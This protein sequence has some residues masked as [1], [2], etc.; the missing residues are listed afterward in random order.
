MEL[1]GTNPDTRA[2]L[3]VWAPAFLAALA[4]TGAQGA[5]CKAAGVGRTTVWRHR[6]LDPAFEEACNQALQDFGESL[7]IEAVRR[8]RDG[9]VETYID[10]AGNVHETRT[11]S[12]KLLE[13]L[14][15]ANLSHKYRERIDVLVVLR[16]EARRIAEESGLDAAELIAEAERIALGKA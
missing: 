6:Q 8:A 4:E 15:R 14:L 9:I 5:S 7:E 2:S 16:N 1:S 13:T 3:P 12:D 10:K 11:Y